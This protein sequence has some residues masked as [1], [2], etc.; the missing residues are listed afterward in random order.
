VR[1]ARFGRSRPDASCRAAT[2][3]AIRWRMSDRETLGS[4]SRAPMP[5]PRAVVTTAGGASLGRFRP[6]ASIVVSPG[7]AVFGSD[8][9]RQLP[10]PCT[11][12]RR[13]TSSQPGKTKLP[14]ADAG[15]AASSMSETRSIVSCKEVLAH[16]PERL[17]GGFDPTVEELTHPFAA[18][19]L[20]FA[21]SPLRELLR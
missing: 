9:E 3:V 19:P 10:A 15:Y 6:L 1:R 12:L 13:S 17:G 5:T 4:R 11:G 2:C 18:A 7:T 20:H 8:A 14:L 16:S 21:A